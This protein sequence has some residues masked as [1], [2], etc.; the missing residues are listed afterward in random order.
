MSLRKDCIS[1]EELSPLTGENGVLCAFP[2]D[3]K[4]FEQ[5][6]LAKS[7][8]DSKSA[9]LAQTGIVLCFH[10]DPIGL[11]IWLQIIIQNQGTSPHPSLLQLGSWQD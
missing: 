2:S 11:K 6:S 8:I 9:I 7:Y 5:N 3:T 4:G 10:A 1:K